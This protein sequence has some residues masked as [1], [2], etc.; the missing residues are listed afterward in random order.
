MDHA[1]DRDRRLR[2]SVQIGAV[3]AALLLLLWATDLFVQVRLLLADV[4]FVPRPVSGE[5]VI[6]AIDDASLA[7]YGRFSDWPRTLHATLVQTLSEA[8]ARVIAFDILFAESAPGD[9]RLARAI[10]D[11]RRSEARTRVVLPLVGVQ[12]GIDVPGA[13]GY[14]DVVFPATLLR[15]AAAMVAT[16]NV[17]PD[18]DGTIRWLPGFIDAQGETVPS[19]AVAAYLTQRGVSVLT[20]PQVV[21][22]EPGVLHLPGE[23]DV[24]VN[25]S[26]QMLIN[27]FSTPEEPAFPVYSFRDVIEGAVDPAVF[28]DRIVLVGL[29]E[30]TALTDSYPVPNSRSGA[31]MAGVEIQANA[32]EMLLQDLTLHVQSPLSQAM[33]IIVLAVLA[34]VI[35]GQLSWRWILLVQAGLILLVIV[36]GL[37]VFNLALLVTNLFHPLLAL[38]IPGPVTVFVYNVVGTRQRQR[39]EFLLRSALAAA[40][41]RLNATGI[42]ASIADDLGRLL[43]GAAVEVTP[44]RRVK[45][46]VPADAEIVLEGVI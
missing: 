40:D 25:D 46:D 1:L 3:V 31:L 16:V 35:Y 29:M 34:S 37:L 41:Q 27:Y 12:R 9:D 32:V 18:S 17:L 14:A 26:G 23:R 28:A 7:A 6:V 36:G 24:P 20:L 15:E 11:A 43:R 33:T 19:L 22:Y 2:L 39:I 4:F 30:Q 10:A 45:L 44:G 38:L 13:V 21:N 8:G 42:A 5:V